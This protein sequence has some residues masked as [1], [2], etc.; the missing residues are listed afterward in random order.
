MTH[1]TLGRSHRLN[2]AM[3]KNEVIPTLPN[4]WK[5]A[6]ALGDNSQLIR[7]SDRTLVR[8]FSKVSCLLGKLE[9]IGYAE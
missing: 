7:I 4:V 8:E 5:K 2:H 3:S 1:Q 9:E 6:V